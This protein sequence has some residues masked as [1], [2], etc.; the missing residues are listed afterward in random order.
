VKS[1]KPNL[2]AFW[3]KTSP[4][5]RFVGSGDH[6][7]DK[8]KLARIE[9]NGKNAMFDLEGEGFELLLE[10]SADFFSDIPAV[11]KLLTGV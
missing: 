3:V 1:V 10:R 7:G 6:F 11:S 8:I 5:M 9:R 4:K 2:P